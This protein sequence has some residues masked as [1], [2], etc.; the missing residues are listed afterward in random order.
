MCWQSEGSF[1]NCNFALI[2]LTEK[3]KIYSQC[4]TVNY[5]AAI[6]Q[7]HY[8]TRSQF[9]KGSLVCDNEMLVIKVGTAQH[10]VDC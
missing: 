7:W 3:L 4:H 2:D 1:R 5:C 9:D 6:Y 10:T 8:V